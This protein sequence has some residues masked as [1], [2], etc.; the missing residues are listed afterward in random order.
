MLQAMQLI[1][2][3][4]SALFQSIV[5]MLKFAFDIGYLM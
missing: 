3:N 5:V 1:L 2:A 4:Q